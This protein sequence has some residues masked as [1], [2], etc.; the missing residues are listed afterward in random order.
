VD[1]LIRGAEKGK[2]VSVI[3][4]L[5]ARFDEA[6]NIVGAK[7][8]EQ[9]GA[10]VIYGVQGLKTHAKLCI[11]VRR[12]SRGVQRY[13]HFG[14]GNYNEATARLYSDISY[15]TNNEML[16]SDAV[17]FFNAITGLSVPQ[18]FQALAAAPIDLRETLLDLIQAE[19][20][21]ARRGGAAAIDAKLNSLV[22][23]KI[24]D[25]LYEAS[26]QGV[27]IRLNIRGI[28][29]LRPGIPGLSENIDV[30]SIVDR[31]LE[32]SRIVHFYH[33]G[34][35]LIFISSA[36]WMGR[37]LNRRAELL[38]PVLNDKCR[39]KLLEVLGC[40]FDDNVASKRLTSTGTYQ[41]VDSSAT[42]FRVQEYL[43]EQACDWYQVFANP[44]A[45]VFRAH[46]GDAV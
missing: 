34:E 13:V 41:P 40:Y 9:A 39:F 2:Q 24:I 16:G 42:P 4:E 25:A 7:R 27:K 28:C 21:T 17:K 23:T 15:F 31:F 32:H 26:S 11:V 20:E 33:G 29:C 46:R 35:N 38:I 36:D 6:R 5:K 30:V 14:T 1:E 8:L 3:V 12:E 43:Y 19:T 37:S 45:T 10:D 22:D 44:K 18:P